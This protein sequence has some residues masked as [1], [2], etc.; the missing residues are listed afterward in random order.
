MGLRVGVVGVWVWVWVVGEGEGE[1]WGEGGA[2]A[3]VEGCEGVGADWDGMGEAMW[4]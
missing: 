3:G 2:G 4:D 1:V